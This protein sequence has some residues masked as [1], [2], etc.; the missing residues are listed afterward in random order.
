MAAAKCQ[1]GRPK[2]I[3]LLAFLF[4]TRRLDPSL[5][6]TRLR[7]VAMREALIVTSHHALDAAV[8]RA[9]ELSEEN[10]RMD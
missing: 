1:A 6:R 7:D 2:D 10:G 9:K 3:E 8:T 4:A 5:A